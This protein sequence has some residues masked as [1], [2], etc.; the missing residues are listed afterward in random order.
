[1]D[2]SPLKAVQMRDK[3]KLLRLADKLSIHFI[4]EDGTEEYH[5]STSYPSNLEKKMKIL[6]RFTD[7]M[8]HL[9]KAGSNIE[10]KEADIQSRNPSIWKWFRTTKAVVMVLTNG[11]LQI[12]FFE[13][14]SKIILC[15]LLGAVTWIDGEQ[16]HKTFSLQLIQKY[17]CCETLAEKLGYA[18]EKLYTI[19]RSSSSSS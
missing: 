8:G 12:N 9:A 1:M 5:T 3:T 7:H 2:E 10:V 13:D 19:S 18:R 11:T 17:G 16:N 6:R 4:N 15:P 14:H